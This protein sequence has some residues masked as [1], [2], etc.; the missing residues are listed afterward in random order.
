MEKL[1]EPLTSLLQPPWNLL[2]AA[3]ALLT[4]AGPRLVDLRQ[5]WVDVRLGRRLLETPPSLA[6]GAEPASAA[7]QPEKELGWIGR[8]AVR[9][10]AIGRPLMLVV[11]AVLAYLMVSFAV[12]A[13][14]IPF[15]GLEET[16]LGLGPSLGM[17]ALYALLLSWASY[18]AFKSAAEIRRRTAAG[19]VGATPAG[20][21]RSASTG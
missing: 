4:L 19:A 13:I 5:T 11:Q 17:T 10:P 6:P 16:G 15:F 8:F 14:V 9:N 18:R 12:I 7:P 1:L 21:P 20:E 3:A 2:L